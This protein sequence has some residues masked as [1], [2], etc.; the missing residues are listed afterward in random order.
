MRKTVYSERRRKIH[1][2]VRNI[3]KKLGLSSW[4]N[5]KNISALE[6]DPLTGIYNQFGINVYLKELRHS[7]KQNYAIVLLNLDNFKDIQHSFGLKAAEKALVKTA[8]LLTQNIRDTDLVGRY[9]EHEFILILCDIELDDANDVAQRCLNVIQ[10]TPIRYNAQH[11]DLHAS[12]GVSVSDEDAVS[13]KI[14]QYADRALYLA[15]ISGFNQL[16]DQRA[17]LG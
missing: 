10:N 11:I 7:P 13:D 16:R 2:V 9:G 1:I 4:L 3:F 5:P 6:T 8:R 12:C 14:L 15:K 17:V